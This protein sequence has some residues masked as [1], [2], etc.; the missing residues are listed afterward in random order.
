MIPKIAHFYWGNE[1]LSFLRYMTVWSFIKFNPDWEVRFYYPKN[2]TTGQ[3][4]P[5]HEHKYQV[6]GEDFLPALQQ[7]PVYWREVDFSTLLMNDKIS[8]VHRSDFLRWHI[9]STEGGLWSDM[10]ILYF[11][12]INIDLQFDTYLCINPQYGH[13]IGFILSS[14]GNGVFHC[15]KQ[16]ALHGFNP[17][18]Y[19]S[20]GSII[21]NRLYPVS[22]S[23][24]GI[25]N[26]PMDIVYAYNALMIPKIFAEDPEAP[27]KFTDR[28]IGLHWYAGHQMAGKYINLVNINNFNNFNNVLGQAL[29]MATGGSYGDV[30]AR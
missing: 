21:L 16:E 20:M 30:V 11:K 26:L 2:R 12:G 3:T 5:T 8:E 19:Q 22:A 9:L 23:F 6:S 24:G 25:Y 14:P 1:T 29:R 4:W 15:I 17:D 10:D 13:S 7:L 18:N 27:L 28:S